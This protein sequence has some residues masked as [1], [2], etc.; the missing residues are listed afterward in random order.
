MEI[1]QNPGEFNTFRHD[2]M[3]LVN[4]AAFMDDDDFVIIPQPQQNRAQIINLNANN[5]VARVVDLPIANRMQEVPKTIIQAVPNPYAIVTD[6]IDRTKKRDRE[7]EM[8]IEDNKEEEKQQ[9]SDPFIVKT[10][11]TETI[12]IPT[13]NLNQNMPP[14][15]YNLRSRSIPKVI[16]PP[17]KKMPQNKI[18]LNPLVMSAQVDT[19]RIARQHDKILKEID[20]KRIKQTNDGNTPMDID[21]LDRIQMMD[22]NDDLLFKTPQT[23][24]RFNDNDNGGPPNDGPPP[25]GPQ[26]RRY[27]G[28]PTNNYSGPNVLKPDYTNQ[29]TEKLTGTESIFNTRR[30]KDL[31]LENPEISKELGFLEAF[32]PYLNDFNIPLENCNSAEKFM[33]M[34]KDA[35]T[36]KISDESNDRI[37][38]LED[39]LLHAQSRAD[40]NNRK[41]EEISG[42]E[43]I[44]LELAKSKDLKESFSNSM[45]KILEEVEQIKIKNDTILV[46]DIEDIIKDVSISQ[47]LNSEEILKFKELIFKIIQIPPEI[48]DQIDNLKKEKYLLEKKIMILKDDIEKYKLIEED[49][50]QLEKEM[51]IKS[52]DLEKN[53]RQIK[54]T[55]YLI[56]KLDKLPRDKLRVTQ[57]NFKDYFDAN[58]QFLEDSLKEMQIIFSDVAV[59]KIFPDPEK[60]I[61]ETRKNLEE[62]YNLSAWW[63][64]D[65][66]TVGKHTRLIMNFNDIF[67]MMMDKMVSSIDNF[68]LVD[69]I[70][71][72]YVAHYIEN[73]SIR[74]EQKIFAEHA[75]RAFEVGSEKEAALNKRI[76]ELIESTKGDESTKLALMKRQQDLEARTEK[77]KADTSNKITGLTEDLTL[78]SQEII[79]LNREKILLKDQLSDAIFKS[80]ISAEEKAKLI[81]DLKQLREELNENILIMENVKRSYEDQ[82]IKNNEYDNRISTIN[83]KLINTISLID[84]DPT[85]IDNLLSDKLI[86]IIKKWSKEYKSV[87]EEVSDKDNVKKVLKTIYTKLSNLNNFAFHSFQQLEVEFKNKVALLSDS[88]IRVNELTNA[89]ENERLKNIKSISSLNNE[90]SKVETALKMAEEKITNQTI[91][92]IQADA[93]IRDLE[94]ELSKKMIE[95]TRV[96]N[97]SESIKRELKHCNDDKEKLKDELERIKE[98]NIKLTDSVEDYIRKIKNLES[99]N[100]TTK[101]ELQ[102]AICER[103]RISSL[104]QQLQDE[105]L[106]N[107][108]EISILQEQSSTIVFYRTKEINELK[109]K[110]TSLEKELD[111]RE[112][113]LNS[114][115][116]RLSEADQKIFNSELENRALINNLK[117]DIEKL[118]NSLEMKNIE[119]ESIKDQLSKEKSNMNILKM[120]STGNKNME[121][122]LNLQ[123]QELQRTR[124]TD[125]DQTNME[126]N[127]QK[128]AVQHLM[129]EINKYTLILEEKN[130]EIEKM[131]NQLVNSS[132]E[133]EKTV[134]SYEIKLIKIQKQIDFFRKTNEE[135]SSE[136]SIQKIKAESVMFDV[137][138]LRN[139]IDIL[140]KKISGHNEAMADLE[141]NSENRLKNIQEQLKKVNIENIESKTQAQRLTGEL[142]N[143]KQLLDNS[144]QSVL[145]ARRIAIDSLYDFFVSMVEGETDLQRTIDVLFQTVKNGFR[146]RI[147]QELRLI[148]QKYNPG[149]PMNVLYTSI[150][151]GFCTDYFNEQERTFAEIGNFEYSEI[152]TLFRNAILQSGS[153]SV[154]SIIERMKVRNR[155]LSFDIITKLNL[156]A[157]W[158]EGRYSRFF[159][160]LIMDPPSARQKEF[161]QLLFN[162]AASQLHFTD[163]VIEKMYQCFRK[164]YNSNSVSDEYEIAENFIFYG[165]IKNDWK[166]DPFIH[167]LDLSIKENQK[168]LMLLARLP[169]DIKYFG[170]SANTINTHITKIAIENMFINEANNIII[171]EG[172]GDVSLPESCYDCIFIGPYIEEVNQQLNQNRYSFKLV[173]FY[174]YSE[175]VRS[176]WISEKKQ[177]VFST[178]FNND[179]AIP[180]KTY[181]MILPG[182]FFRDLGV[183]SPPLETSIAEEIRK[184]QKVEQLIVARDEIFKEVTINDQEYQRYRSKQE[185]FI[186]ICV[187]SGVKGHNFFIKFSQT[188]INTIDIVHDAA[189][190]NLVFTSTGTFEAV[191]QFVGMNA[192]DLLSR[193]ENPSEYYKIDPTIFTCHSFIKTCFMIYQAYNIESNKAD[194]FDFMRILM[195]VTLTKAALAITRPGEVNLIFDEVSKQVILR[196]GVTEGMQQLLNNISNKYGLPNVDQNLADRGWSRLKKKI[197][198]AETLENDDVSQYLMDQIPEESKN[199]NKV[200]LVK[201]NQLKQMQEAVNQIYLNIDQTAAT[202]AIAPDYEVD[203]SNYLEKYSY[204]PLESDDCSSKKIAIDKI[205]EKHAI[206]KI[207]KPKKETQ[208][209]K[210]VRPTKWTK[211]ELFKKPEASE[212]QLANENEN[213]II[214]VQP[215]ENPV[216]ADVPVFKEGF[217]GKLQGIEE[218]VREEAYKTEI[219]TKLSESAAKVVINN[220]L[221]KMNSNILIPEA[222]PNIQQIVKAQP[223]SLEPN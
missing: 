26:N 159:N 35:I 189:A 162:L 181:M 80:S 82:K 29:N 109:Q 111:S 57:S 4:D 96:L 113:N 64:L 49:L 122:K 114:S 138:N 221:S 83:K 143:M 220:I 47:N 65:Y 146:R 27:Y 223:M 32:K 76:Q 144:I 34:L 56:S 206:K 39:R 63:K 153:N 53:K 37:M 18:N 177:I 5:Q 136:L 118:K 208:V 132:S 166:D 147:L 73:M 179:R 141:K 70:K 88:K 89:L 188:I 108:K 152:E 98:K 187:N 93:K 43:D 48:M 106:K 204:K 205:K 24:Y 174:I 169:N 196:K 45:K 203:P 117:A 190:T 11:T 7:R 20:N 210:F 201:K 127:A 211:N 156:I 36:K 15:Q 180:D 148:G 175:G 137:E 183:G 119:V 218:V 197:N 209:K 90:K 75:A 71:F 61:F 42:I 202:E 51:E 12:V 217:D 112:Q 91:E 55:A 46:S 134:E 154:P 170:I 172:R 21:P 149:N 168:G 69:E 155:R 123:I 94:R 60:F 28:E 100:V 9:L 85:D 125:I 31:D 103:E 126:I 215:L 97:E 72:S 41:I 52:Q 99:E 194:E 165:I 79:E 92:K 121:D 139:E 164:L 216:I 59:Q 33:K 62:I 110:I 86:E 207:K 213:Q 1:Y 191:I 128:Q 158:P 58:M 161:D 171:P 38:E 133:K 105:V 40:D 186:S 219:P 167:I 192:E 81:I 78:K 222:N 176:I 178:I 120:Q 212:V 17:L 2:I 102:A 8:D 214:L 115:R 145:E 160:K 67:K 77:L 101:M 195:S 193:V 130:R 74:F 140:R 185:R 184:R 151:P 44:K 19:D 87:F 13:K 22:Y 3:D 135:L 163:Q 182:E 54:T 131:K 50:K 198:V 199:F 124:K 129:K 30:I 173:Y 16:V 116:N 14:P 95:V 66:K 23:S 25:G 150:L 84:V 10:S 68:H 142:N 157:S 107:N 104:L 200:A 6:Y